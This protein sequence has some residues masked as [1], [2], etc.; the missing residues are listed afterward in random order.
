MYD[1]KAKD[2]T[3]KYLKEKREKLELNLLVGKT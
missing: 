2:H 1:E 3:I